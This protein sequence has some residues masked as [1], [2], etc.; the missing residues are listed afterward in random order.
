MWKENYDGKM[1]EMLSEENTYKQLDHDP[2]QALE[3]SL[4]TL[5]L[6]LKREGSIRVDLYNQLQSSGGLTPH[7]YSLTKVHKPGF[8]QRPIVRRTSSLS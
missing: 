2:S 3:R 1:S 8:P 5:L 7:L 4:N 6:Q